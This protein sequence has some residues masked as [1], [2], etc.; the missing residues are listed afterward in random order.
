LTDRADRFTVVLDANVIAGALPRNILLSLAEAGFFR[1]RWSAQ[2]LG[3][4]E[5]YF[6]QQFHDSA[7]AARQRR[8]MEEAFP[9][10]EVSNHEAL[11]EAVDLPDKK[12]R[13]VLAAAVHTKAA[14][15]VTDN[16]KDFPSEVL[17]RYEIEAV[18]LDDFVADI[19]DLAGAEAIAALRGMRRRF[20]KPALDAEALIAKIENAGL[21]ETAKI[22]Y[23]YRSLL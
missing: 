12:D 5:A 16:L 7:G 18:G 3:E 13:H 14:L 20:R 1:P 9:E 19:L 4:F 10:A 23:E 22:L 8:R 2:I 21:Q 15:I 11:L 6:T 17:A